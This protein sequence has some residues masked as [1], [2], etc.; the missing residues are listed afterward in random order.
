MRK[1]LTFLIALTALA[2]CDASRRTG[3]IP[4]PVTSANADSV[5]NAMD[6]RHGDVVGV[7]PMALAH[8]FETLPEGGNIV[9]ERGEHD[10]FGISQIR[11]H[12]LKISRSFKR[13]DFAI[14]GFIHTQTVPGADMMA[15]KSGKID[16]IVEDLP[17][18]GAI[19][20][21]TSDPDALRAVHSFIAFQIAEHRTAR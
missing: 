2:A 17:H 11:L 16:Y 5:F 1:S 12:L 7:D 4:T 15:E 10:D 8:R 14:P 3:A 13:G 19:H 9:L 6:H 20:I 18:G 21:R